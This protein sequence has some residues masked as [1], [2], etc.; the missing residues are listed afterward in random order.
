MLGLAEPS[1]L[2][3]LCRAIFNGAL[4]FGFLLSCAQW[5]WHDATGLICSDVGHCQTKTGFLL[6]ARLSAFFKLLII[7][8]MFTA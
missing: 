7:W 6:S 2:E 4:A 1:W 3:E 5:I 8:T